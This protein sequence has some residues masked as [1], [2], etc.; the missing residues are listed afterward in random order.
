MALIYQTWPAGRQPPGRARSGL[1]GPDRDGSV[2]LER[3]SWSEPV[4]VAIAVTSTTQPRSAAL[5]TRNLPRR[6]VAA[7]FER[8]AWRHIRRLPLPL[9]IPTSGSKALSGSRR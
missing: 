1:V 8:A 6:S 4:G 7:S 5:P 9:L 3:D 2:R